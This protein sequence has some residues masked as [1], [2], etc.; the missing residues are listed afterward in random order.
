MVF[1][2]LS[3]IPGLYIIELLQFHDPHLD[4]RNQDCAEQKGWSHCPGSH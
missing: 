1:H 3:E 2:V 4:S